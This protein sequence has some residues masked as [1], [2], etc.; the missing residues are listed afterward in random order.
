MKKYLSY[1][2]CT[3]A[4]LGACGAARADMTTYPSTDVTWTGTP[5]TSVNG[6]LVSLDPST[7]VFTDPNGGVPDTSAARYYGGVIKYA[8]GANSWGG[9]FLIHLLKT[10]DTPPGVLNEQVQFG[11]AQGIDNYWIHGSV[12]QATSAVAIDGTEVPFVIKIEDNAWNW[13]Y[14]KLF[15]GAKA[16]AATE[17]ATPDALVDLINA[18]ATTPIT[19]FAVTY[20]TEDWNNPVNGGPNSGQLKGFF[21]STA[22]APADAAL[23]APPVP[24]PA[25][26]GVLGL[27]AAAL[28]FKARRRR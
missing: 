22:W 8:V 28:A 16:L 2:L 14:G 27:G 24:E 12:S 7:G 18:D 20:G 3:L 4:A 26:L 17:N 9:S 5:G 25:T 21:S 10:G 13:A 11:G 15:L 6:T 23:Q 1:C 19:G